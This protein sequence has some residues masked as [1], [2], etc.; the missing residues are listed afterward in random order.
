MFSKERSEAFGF[1]IQMHEFPP[2]LKGFVVIG[3]NIIS[4]RKGT[5]WE[6]SRRSVFVTDEMAV[7]DLFRNVGPFFFNPI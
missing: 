3:T 4:V 6:S 5:M 1:F 7:G 2:K